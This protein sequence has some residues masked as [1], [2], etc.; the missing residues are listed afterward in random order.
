[1]RTGRTR[2]T[3][4]GRGGYVG[5]VLFIIIHFVY[6]YT[7]RFS[8]VDWGNVV[9]Y[10]DTQLR[11]SVNGRGGAAARPRWSWLGTSTR[12][13]FSS[14]I[15]FFNH[16]WQVPA[17]A[18]PRVTGP[19]CLPCALR[20]AGTSRHIKNQNTT[21]N[22]RFVRDFYVLDLIVCTVLCSSNTHFKRATWWRPCTCCCV[23][24]NE[25][26][27]L[28]SIGSG[29]FATCARRFRTARPRVP[30]ASGSRANRLPRRA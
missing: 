12:C 25:S 30:I 18:S 26:P 11:F 14:Y 28:L 19:T 3:P 22:T 27:L 23:S 21:P 16:H 17:M 1:L 24:E 5:T 13:C 2:R 20:L 4:L 10:A 7:F 9:P 8:T 29:L 6:H 15:L